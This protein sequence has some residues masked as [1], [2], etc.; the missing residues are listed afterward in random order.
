M[1]QF[2][3]LVSPLRL[4]D[5]QGRTLCFHHPRWD[6]EKTPPETQAMPCLGEKALEILLVSYPHVWRLK[7]SHRFP[8]M[9]V[10]QIIQT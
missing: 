6:D 9:V 7:L 5:F 10:P 1:H 3:L 2:S 8:K 4:V